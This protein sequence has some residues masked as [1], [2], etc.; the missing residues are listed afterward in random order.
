MHSKRGL[1]AVQHQSLRHDQILGTVPE[2]TSSRQCEG[3]LRVAQGRP[4]A[5]T[6]AYGTGQMA[7]PLGAGMPDSVL[8]PSASRLQS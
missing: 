2:L 5:G 6:T 8:S 1:P 4:Q 7:T 3:P